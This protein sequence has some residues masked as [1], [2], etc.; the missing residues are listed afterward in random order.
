MLEFKCRASELPFGNCIAWLFHRGDW[1]N[2]CGWRTRRGRASTW[3]SAC[4]E[5][6]DPSLVHETGGG[7]L[8]E[9]INWATAQNTNSQSP[10]YRKLDTSKVAVA[11]HSCGGLQALEVS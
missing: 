2:V 7:T 1:A 6:R 8:L 3:C 9:A 5:W 11:G 10:Y 4:P